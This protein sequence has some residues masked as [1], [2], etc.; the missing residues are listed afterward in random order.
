MNWVARYAHWLHGQWPA[1][2][3]EPLP[4]VDENGQTAISGVYIVGDLKGIPLLK[5]SVDSGTK[6]VMHIVSGFKS[7]VSET[8]NAV[9]DVVIVGAGVSG[10]AA[11]LEAKARG[12]SF[13][14]FEGSEPFSTIVN[15]P[16]A[17]PIYTYP[18]EMQPEGAL[19]V[20]A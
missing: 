14:V 9:L 18:V 20:T 8:R 3:V 10:M 15:F 16:K 1:G 17:K 4:E 19:Q 11:A 2:Q 12:L 6:A 7:Q 13:K 5:F